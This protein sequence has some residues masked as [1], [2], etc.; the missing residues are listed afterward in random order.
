MYL[1]GG[2]IS[3]PNATLRKLSLMDLAV[4]MAD[5]PTTVLRITRFS[6]RI[7]GNTSG[8]VGVAFGNTIFLPQEF[9]DVSVGP[10]DWDIYLC[11]EPGEQGLAH[12]THE[13][14]VFH[15]T[16]TLFLPQANFALMQEL[17]AGFAESDQVIRRITAALPA[18]QMVD[19]Q[20]NGILTLSMAAAALAGVI[21]SFKHVLTDIVLVIL[22]AALVVVS[23]GKRPALQHRFETLGIEFC[24]LDTNLHDGQEAADPL[25]RCDML[26]DLDLYGRSQPALVLAA[27]PV[28][29]SRSTVAGFPTSS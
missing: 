3:S 27:C 28:V 16:A 19:V 22:F 10:I 29:E 24:S 2:L 25:D 15:R 8:I 1:I 4:M 23:H 5:R 7:A 11:P 12:D 9:G 21:V 14:G 17:M 13:G 18:L 26:L 6:I 20:L